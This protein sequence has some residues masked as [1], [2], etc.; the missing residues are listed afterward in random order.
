MFG[1]AIAITSCNCGTVSLLSEVPLPCVGSSAWP[2]LSVPGGIFRE[3]L[4]VKGTNINSSWC[5]EQHE[6]RLIWRHHACVSNSLMY[7]FYGRWHHNNLF[8]LNSDNHN[9][10]T[11]QSKNFYHPLTNF[12]V[13]QKGVHY[14][15][16]R[17]F[18]NLPPYIKEESQNVRK[19]KN[20]LKWFLHTH[21]FYSIE[22][23]FQ[24]KANIS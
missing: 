20:C 11:R 18:N 19:F 6:G 14:M 13:Y 9:T 22:E 8:I 3:L 16:I 10:G 24:Y 5:R 21:Y 23:Y 15:G 17:V 12:T 7:R 2:V 1:L 4:V